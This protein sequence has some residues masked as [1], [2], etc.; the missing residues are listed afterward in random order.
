VTR[1]PERGEAEESELLKAV[2][3]ERLLKIQQADKN[4]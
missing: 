4:A 2:A 1:G 3:R